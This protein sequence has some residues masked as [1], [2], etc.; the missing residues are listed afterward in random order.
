[1]TM[2]IFQIHWPTIKALEDKGG[3]DGREGE[4]DE[5]EEEGEANRSR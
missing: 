5:A 2:F 4:K 3:N 1:M